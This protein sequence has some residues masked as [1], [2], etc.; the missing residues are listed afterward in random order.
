M[1][2]DTALISRINPPEQSAHLLSRTR[3]LNL[4]KQNQDKRLIVVCSPVGY[5]KTT[6]VLDYLNKMSIKFA[7]VNVSENIDHI[8]SFY[9]YIFTALQKLHPEFGLHSI[10]LLDSYLEK[11]K[12]H[13][14]LPES[15]IDITQTFCKEFKKYFTEKTALIL[16]DYHHVEAVKWK[17]YAIDVLLKNIPDN[18]QLIITSR[19]LPELDFT[20]YILNDMM[21]KIEMEEMIFNNKEIEELVNS[22]YKLKVKNAKINEI[23]KKI[24]GWVT[25]VHLIFQCSG[26]DIDNFTI[27]EQPIPENIFDSLADKI[28]N[29]L[30]PEQQDFL[31]NTSV[32]DNF[33]KQ[34]C[35]EVLGIEGFGELIDLLI[36][37]ISFIHKIPLALEDGSTL[38]TYNYLNLQRNYLKSK[39]YS[40][41]SKSEIKQLFR[42]ISDYYIGRNDILTSINYM[43]KAHDNETAL[44]YINKYFHKFF[45]EGKIESLWTWLN[46]IGM[47]LIEKDAESLINFAVMHKFYSGDL[48]YSLRLSAMAIEKLKTET[49]TDLLINAYINQAGIML[50]LGDTSKV[51]NDF[52]LLIKDPQ[53][54]K[55]R[56]HLSYYLAYAYFH[57]S[58]YQTSKTILLDILL[59][60]A[61]NPENEV[62]VNINKLLGHIYLIT[63]NFLK[64][65]SF[66]GEIADNNKNILDRFEVLCNLVLLSSQAGHYEKAHNYLSSLEEIIQDFPTPVFNI[67]FLLASQSYY[68]EKGDFNKAIGV[69]IEIN[70]TALSIGHKKY[71]YLSCRLLTECYF[72]NKDIN[73]AGE[74]FNISLKYKDEHNLLKNIELETSKAMIFDLTLS[75]KEKILLEAN[76]FYKDD[77]LQYNLAQNCYYLSRLY[78]LKGEKTKFRIYFDECLESCRKNGYKSFL[79]R[80]KKFFSKPFVE[81]KMNYISDEFLD[82]IVGEKETSVST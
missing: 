25:G 57:I 63:G 28:F 56:T 48:Q 19:Q 41:K 82:S 5:G 20:H 10:K 33:E 21:L 71:L 49:R 2:L 24:G 39:L 29:D 12:F 14:D 36:K 26:N 7:W 13:K 11:N 50:N 80:E 73:K 52:T 81:A 40:S 64:A 60:S 76:K 74:F 17:D 43:V 38:D 34:I 1:N 54:K 23:G 65:L 77:N 15:V 27:E 78:L 3:L 46:N 45:N 66:Y 37:K 75:E 79:M 47:K 4:I 30:T 67:P 59:E 6:L 18:L 55:Y 31:K 22:V 32:I 16:D 62:Y 72:Y 35:N 42:K 44:K 8:Y 53:F 51:I 61:S 9:K 69:L 68:F 70:N 58:E